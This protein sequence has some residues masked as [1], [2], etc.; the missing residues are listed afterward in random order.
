MKLRVWLAALKK[1]WVVWAGIIG[2]AALVVAVDPAEV[3]K[4][5]AGAD[6]RMVALMLPV[7]FL[8]YLGHGVAWWIALRGVGSKVSLRRAVQVT[9][10]SQ[11]FDLLPG[12]DLWRVPIVKSEGGG[13]EEAGKIAASVIFDD[14]AYFFVLTAAVLPLAARDGAL[15]GLLLAALLPQMAIFTIL[16]TPSL[17]RPLVRAVGRIRPIKRFVPQLEMLGPAFRELVRPKV[18]VPVVAMDALCVLLAVSLY[19][20]AVSAVHTSGVSITQI[21]FTYAVGQVVSGLTIVPAALGVYEGVMTGLM[22]LQGA[23]P[24]AA[25]AAILLYRA[26]NDFL[27]AA[28]GVLVAVMA[29][30]S[31]ARQRRQAVEVAMI[32]AGAAQ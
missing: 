7:V 18:L 16:L 26:V 29:D 17:H 27:M 6:G 2:V 11:A 28:I 19:W 5:W 32:A 8:L 31:L 4:A 21:A 10:I 25:T 24:A 3:V 1:H 22:A 13:K 12:G 20:L 23:Q 14:L 30:R 9:F 15:R